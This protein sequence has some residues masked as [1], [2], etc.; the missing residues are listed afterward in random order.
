MKRWLTGLAIVLSQGVMGQPPQGLAVGTLAPDFKA[1]GNDGKVVDLT[2]QLTR[3][4]VVVFF[5]RG[6]WCP[7]CNKQ[8][9][10]L[11][12]SLSLITAKKATVIAVTPETGSNVQTT[13]TKTKARFTI[14]SDSGMVI[15]KK[16]AVAF[17]VDPQTVEK[18]KQYGIDFTV[19]NGSNGANLPVPAVYIINPQGVIT[20]RF[21]DTDYRKRPSVRELLTHL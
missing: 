8:M 18:Y 20:Y 13:V 11:Q 12:D 5:Y 2:Q 9:Q 7:F 19:A 1:M 16:Y 21:F 14:V 4:S 3:G 10:G 17:A 6:Q 15:M